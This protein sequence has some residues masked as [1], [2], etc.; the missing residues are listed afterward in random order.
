[1]LG[2]LSYDFVLVPKD[3]FG[4]SKLSGR[5]SKAG[6]ASS[7]KTREKARLQDT[8]FPSKSSNSM[9]RGMRS[10][11]GLV[12]LLWLVLVLVLVERWSGTLVVLR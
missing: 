2:R 5:S 4:D 12:M 7:P 1:M 10:Q 6:I 3:R 8:K 9:G 11:C